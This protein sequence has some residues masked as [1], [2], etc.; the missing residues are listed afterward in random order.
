[1]RVWRES[2]FCHY[3]RIPLLIFWLRLAVMITG[4]VALKIATWDYDIYVYPAFQ[5]VLFI[6]YCWWFID[7]VV[8]RFHDINQTGWKALYMFLPYVN[9]YF[10][11]K[12]MLKSGTLGDNQYGP[13]PYILDKYDLERL[14]IERK[15]EAIN[16]Q[17]EQEKQAKEAEDKIKAQRQAKGDLKIYYDEEYSKWNEALLFEKEGYVEL[18]PNSD[19]KTERILL[20]D[21]TRV[22]FKFSAFTKTE[23]EEGDSGIGGAAVGYV[24]GG[25]KGAAAEYY[26]DSS[27]DEVTAS[28]RWS[29]LLIVETD[30]KDKEVYVFATEAV[31]DTDCNNYKRMY[32]M[33][34]HYEKN[35][36]RKYI[37]Q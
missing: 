32:A 30:K 20:K 26:L 17:Y 24:L 10:L 25:W 2:F 29:M 13:N 21:I 1:M 8:A 9:F 28:D 4:L 18:R 27:D 5:L 12:L 7:S 34:K 36:I 11:I 6:F 19:K 23:I 3:A 31:T 37:C 33:L 35:D 16:R 15:N 22:E 14:E